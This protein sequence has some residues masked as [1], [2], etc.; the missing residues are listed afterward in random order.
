MRRLLSILAPLVALPLGWM[1]LTSLAPGSSVATWAPCPRNWGWLPAYLPRQSPLVA[2]PF[3]MGDTRVKVCYGSPSLAGRT[4]IGGDAVPFGR[5]WRTGANE[6]T[7]IHADGPFRFGELPLPAGSYAIYT[8]PGAREWQ[9]LVNRSTRQWGL[10]SEY[11]DAVARR[12]V[13]RFAMAPEHLA[14]S[15]ETMRFRAESSATAAVDLVFEW[16][17]TRLRIPLAEGFGEIDFETP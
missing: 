4:M 7:T 11:D 1:A 3:R 12:E 6:P 10:E 16:Q 13:G 2:L 8:I 15:V 5:L 9:I 14:S 17:T